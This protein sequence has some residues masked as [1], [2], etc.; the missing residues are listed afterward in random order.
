MLCD[1]YDVTWIKDRIKKFLLNEKMNDKQAVYFL[2]LSEV[3]DLLDLKKKLLADECYSCWK[4]MVKCPQFEMLTLETKACIFQQRLKLKFKE[5][6]THC[7]SHCEED[8]LINF[9]MVLARKD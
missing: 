9:V 7:Y 2:Y 3:H 5:K 1:E 8:E 4:C 6:K